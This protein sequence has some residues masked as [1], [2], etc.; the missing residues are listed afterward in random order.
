MLRCVAVIVLPGQLT[1]IIYDVIYGQHAVPR[2]VVLSL[3][4]CAVLHF[5]ATCLA[6]DHFSYYVLAC[7]DESKDGFCKH[8]DTT[9]KITRG[10]DDGDDDDDSKKIVIDKSSMNNVCRTC[11]TF[12]GMGG[13]CTE[14]DVFPNATV[15]GTK[16]TLGC[17]GR[18]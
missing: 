16:G 14:I 9:C 2:Y 6:N 10:D 12:A 7:S 15:A 17:C 1:T 5:C 13:A 3:R 18:I 8:V 11:D 4:C